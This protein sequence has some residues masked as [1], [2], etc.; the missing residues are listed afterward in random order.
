MSEFTKADSSVYAIF[1]QMLDEHFPELSSHSFGLLFR[2]S[3]KKSRG[4][5][6]L[7]AICQPTKLM[8]YYAKNDAGNPFDYIMIVDE[9]VWACAS[10]EDRIR[11]IRHELR[12]CFITER[13]ESKLVGHDF[14]DF[15][16]E[17][18][19]NSD[20]P[21][22]ANHLVEV[23]LAGYKQIKDGQKD[24]R[25]NRRDAEDLSPVIKDPQIQTKLPIKGT[26]KVAAEEIGSK[27]RKERLAESIGPND[28][29]KPPRK[30]I[31][32]ELASGIESGVI[33]GLDELARKKGLLPEE[34]AV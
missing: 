10:D 11:I 8:S 31:N 5:V 16:K 25:L 28:G 4:S 9:M 29:G 20:S 24:P 13:G 33:K 14:Q 34:A 12:H 21:N 19:I 26:V 32:N 18:E 22:W 27:E 23:T 30:V 2:D 3:I 15:Y 7:A 17:V 6:I 1:M